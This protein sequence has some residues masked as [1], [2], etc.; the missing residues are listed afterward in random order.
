MVKS[1]K[2]NILTWLKTKTYI[3]TEID[4]KLNNKANTNHNHDNK[5][6]LL[7]HQHTGLDGKVDIICS[8]GGSQTSAGYRKV[9]QLKITKQYFDS[10]VSFEFVQR[11]CRQTGRVHIIFN[12]VTSTDPS[13]KA[14]TYDGVI[15]QPIYLYKESAST[16]VF[17][18]KEQSTYDTVNIRFLPLS[19]SIKDSCTITPLNEFLSDLPT[20]NIQEGSMISATSTR[21]GYMDKTDK[22]KLNSIDD[23][24][25]KTVVDSSLSSSSTN[26][27]QNKVVNSALGGKANSSHSHSISNITNLQ[28][29]LNSKSETGH[30]HD[31]RYYT[32]T[33]MNT[34][35][36][37]KANSSHSHSIGNVTNLQ[38]KLDTIPSLTSK[39]ITVSGT[40][41]NGTIT[42]YKFGK[43]VVME[44][45][46]SKVD[47]TSSWNVVGTV[48]DGYI[49]KL[50]DGAGS[51]MV[52]W[53]VQGQQG[54][55]AQLNIKSTGEIR[56][57]YGN[58]G[59]PA[60][61]TYVTYIVN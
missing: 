7:T 16:W 5:Y 6:S 53:S 22:I 2:T 47:L 50:S 43:I 54:Q 48:P 15:E 8:S 21:A 36:N 23:G 44:L 31:D 13:L 40:N 61:Y 28:S 3:K 46:L 9:F 35:L 30:N 27:V 42:F 45:N 19:S 51:V 41:N 14:F 10:P 17:I 4:S 1:F 57:A 55:S 18:I 26:P 39:T 60:L 33:E 52:F 58:G 32:E 38:S 20:D 12:S 34:K 59:T 24:A 37:G 29:T 56:F 49:P 25:N 11:K